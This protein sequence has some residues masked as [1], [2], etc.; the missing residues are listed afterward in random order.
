MPAPPI[1]DGVGWRWSRALPE[2]PGVDCLPNVE[3]LDR[4]AAGQEGLSR[5]A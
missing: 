4:A 2:G 3:G 1:V 5:G